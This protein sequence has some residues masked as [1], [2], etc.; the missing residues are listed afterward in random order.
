MHVSLAVQVRVGAY[1]PNGG[2]FTPRSVVATAIHKGF[3]WDP[4]SEI[5]DPSNDIALMLLDKAVAE[6]PV[7]LA[8]SE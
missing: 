4:E 7:K 5:W 3:V 8:K 2:A 6:P 1:Q